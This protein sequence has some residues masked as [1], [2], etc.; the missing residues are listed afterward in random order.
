MT[1]FSVLYDLPTLCDAPLQ[2]S[3]VVQVYVFFFKL[4]INK[5]LVLVSIY[6]RM[7]WGC[8]NLQFCGLPVHYLIVL[9]TLK[10]ILNRIKL[11]HN[12]D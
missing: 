7:M 5:H 3:S 4:L 8:L 2:H 11:C 12:L 9:L 10:S 1:S 6:S